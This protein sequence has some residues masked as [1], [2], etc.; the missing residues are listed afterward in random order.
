MMT[1]FQKTLLTARSKAR[2]AQGVLN[3]QAQVVRDQS[4]TYV[5]EQKSTVVNGVKCITGVQT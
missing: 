2:V 1:N 3:V 4:L 5:L